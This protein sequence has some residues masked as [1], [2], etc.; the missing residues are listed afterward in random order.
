M[1]CWLTFFCLLV[2]GV[3]VLCWHLLGSDEDEDLSQEH[4]GTQSVSQ[5]LHVI[6]GQVNTTTIFSGFTW[7][8][9]L[10]TV[11][12]ILL[13]FIVYKV[14][15]HKCYSPTTV[16]QTTEITTATPPAPAPV[17]P[18]SLPMQQQF[19]P[20]H[21]PPSYYTAP[22]PGSHPP[23]QQYSDVVKY[24]RQNKKVNVSVVDSSDDSSSTA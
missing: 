12:L 11:S 2:A 24:V 3:A 19:Y 20:G 21:P 14:V 5:G 15:K 16:V 10:I 6:E 1:F 17:L 9:E 7:W 22:L 4:V 23:P 8:E 18:P 13:A